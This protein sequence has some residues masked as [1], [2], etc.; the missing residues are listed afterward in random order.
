MAEQHKITSTEESAEQTTIPISDMW[1][2]IIGRYDFYYGSVNTKAALLIAFNTFVA[3]SIAFKWADLQQAFINQKAEFVIECILMIALVGASLVSLFYTFQSINPFLG[4]Q[5]RP[6]D[7]HSVI[8]FGDVKDFQ[9]P[10]EYHKQVEKLT[11]RELR[12]DLA[13]QAHSLAAG[14]AL[15]FDYLKRATW[16]VLWVQLPV[17]FFMVAVLFY[18]LA[19]AALWKIGQ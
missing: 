16:W 5:R 12:R 13:F 10:D 19:A 7:Y 4:S 18:S 1:L 11:D 6:N 9:T 8:F 3:G 14:L 15:K 2:K 17:L